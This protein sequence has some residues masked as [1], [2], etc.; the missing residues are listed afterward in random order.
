[1]STRGHLA[2]GRAQ[3]RERQDS[4]TFEERN[5]APVEARRRRAVEETLGCDA[6]YIDNGEPVES[7]EEFFVFSHWMCYST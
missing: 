7:T 2:A 3:R 1:M 5:H 6:A 4:G